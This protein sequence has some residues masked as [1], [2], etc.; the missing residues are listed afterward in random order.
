MNNV[1]RR[2][3]A[4]LVVSAGI[5]VALSAYADRPLWQSSVSFTNQIASTPTM[6]GGFPVP[7]GQNYPNAGTCGSGTFTERT[8]VR[9]S[10]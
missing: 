2:S 3:V 6:G 8:H 9:P 5:L 1:L 7:S 10:R 4:A